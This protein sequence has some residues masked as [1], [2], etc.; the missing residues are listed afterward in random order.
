MRTSIV[1]CVAFVALVSCGGSEPGVVTASP[2]RVFTPRDMTVAAGDTVTWEID[3][4]EAHTV[5]AYEEDLPD[6]AD[7]FA[8]G[9][10]S[11]EE[12]AKD[13]LAEGLIQAGD[14]F[15]M[16]F[17][18]PGTYRYYCIPHEA[19]GMVGTIVVE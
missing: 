18:E 3:G 19:D 10:F 12:E 13:N 5:T 4:D 14:T 16:T 7:Y 9:G 8:S 6:G 11:S 1:S 15:E 2:G 17:E